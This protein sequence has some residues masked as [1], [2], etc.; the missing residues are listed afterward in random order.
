MDCAELRALHPRCASCWHAREVVH[1]FLAT[2]KCYAGGLWLSCLQASLHLH[3]HVGTH[4]L[5]VKRRLASAIGMMD[6]APVQLFLDTAT[7]ALPLWD[8]LATGADESVTSDAVAAAADQIR[9]DVNTSVAGQAGD[10]AVR[11]ASV[12]D[13]WKAGG[14]AAEDDAVAEVAAHASHD[15]AVALMTASLQVRCFKYWLRAALAMRGRK[16]HRWLSA[17]TCSTAWSGDVMVIIFCR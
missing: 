3:L 13:I 9:I 4:C 11:L 12:P 16:E 15:L 7:A 8:L 10:V 5:Q 1:S 2:I 14:S 17:V 6:T